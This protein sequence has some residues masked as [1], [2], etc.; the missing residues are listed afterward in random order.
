[1]MSRSARPR[2]NG[3]LT[4]WTMP[5]DP[6]ILRR[7]RWQ[8]R[9]LAW[10]RG[11]QRRRPK[12]DSSARTPAHLLRDTSLVLAAARRVEPDRARRLAWYREDPIVALGSRTAEELVAEGETTRL[13]AL[14]HAIVAMER[15]GS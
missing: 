14:I 8:M 4:G 12:A 11:A 15:G 13:I 7:H 9:L 1:M 10:W 5:C 2:A 6:L 3:V